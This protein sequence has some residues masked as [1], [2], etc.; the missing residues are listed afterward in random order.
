M[1]DEPDDDDQERGPEVDGESETPKP[2]PLIPRMGERCLIA[3]HT[4]SG[5]TQLLIWVTERLEGSPAIIYDTK[6]E[7]KFEQ[8]PFSTVAETQAEVN[9]AIDKAEFDYIIFR[10]PVRFLANPA[11]L[12]DLLMY[13]YENYR[14]FPCIIDE[15]LTFHINRHAGAGLIA[16]LTRGRSRA[17]T[18]VM[19]TQRPSGFDRFAITEAQTVFAFRLT[20]YQDRKRLGDVVPNFEDLALPPEYSFYFYRIGNDAPILYD[21]IPIEQDVDPGYTDDAQP[22]DEDPEEMADQSGAADT[23][24]KHVFF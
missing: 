21:P 20:D 1:A 7:P 19:C 6:I 23:V 10:P 9:A 12:D 17:I 5:K 22:G 16:I 2:G 4:G 8:L 18:T 24:R 3:G 11:A 14:G 15:L 13:H